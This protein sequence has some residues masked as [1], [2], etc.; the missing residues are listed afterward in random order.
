[1]LFCMGE[2]NLANTIQYFNNH[3]AKTLQKRN[4]STCL[5]KLSSKPPLRLS[6]IWQR[7]PFLRHNIGMHSLAL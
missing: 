4:P 7:R 5:H 1:M 6:C 2:T 3:H